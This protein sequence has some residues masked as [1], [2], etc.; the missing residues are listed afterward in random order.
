MVLNRLEFR[1]ERLGPIPGRRSLALSE[2]RQ[3]LLPRGI[4]HYHPIFVRRGEG[5]LLEDVD[6]NVFIDFASG[7]GCLTVGSGPEEVVAAV[8]EQADRLLF[9]CVHVAMHEPYLA[10]V[11]KLTGLLP[12]ATPKK[13]MLVNSGAEAVENAVKLARA[14]TKRKAILTF[15]NSFHGRTLL[16]LALTSKT[17]TYKAGFGPFPAEV[18]RL[19]F[20]YC[21]RCPLTR[22]YPECEIACADLLNDAF[23]HQV[24]PGDV[25]ALIVEPVQG[26]GGIVVPPA[27]YL[28]KLQDTCREHGILFIVDEVQT[29]FAR[30]GF[31]FAFQ[32]PGLEPDLV[33]LSKALADGLPLSAVLGR[34]EILDS[35]QVGGLGG[36]FGGNPV[37]CAAALKV[38]EK[39]EREQLCT[40]AT[41]IG[42]QILRRA[43]RWQ[44]KIA[45]IGDIRA[46]GAMVGI[47]F[48]E[49]RAGKEPATEFVAK[50]KMECLRRGLVLISAGTHANVI[51]FLIPLV[52]DDSTL[53]Q[54]LD[55]MENSM[56]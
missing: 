8:H 39:I 56:M 31:M 4:Y 30:T 15:Q 13:G 1:P 5:A 51:R 52:I 12:G 28:C 27:E 7:L 38:L 19:P 42:S 20:A 3:T 24:A 17:K 16:A 33:I 25:A 29:G 23:E 35:A 32:Q 54:G 34:G 45:C 18:Y 2:L 49:S 36:T 21:Y 22:T 11:E 55:I 50:L 37:S 14:F 10:L 44:E 6:G 46:Q 9:S 43:R 47:E 48:V 26:E 40:R 41:Q 53:Q